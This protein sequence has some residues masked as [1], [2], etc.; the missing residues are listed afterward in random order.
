MLAL[1]AC[2]D[3]ATT[4]SPAAML[5][6][7]PADQVMF[8]VEHNM[9]TQGIRR[10]VLHGDT[11]FVH[12]GG[13]RIDVVGVR[14]VFFDENG[15][16]T[17]TLTSNTGTYQLRAGS[18]VAHGNAVLRTEGDDGTERTIE[19]EE[20]HFDV[21]GDRLWSEQPTVMREGGRILRGTSFESDG[22]FQNVTVRR[23]E[24]DGEPLNR[25]G[26]EITF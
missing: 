19:T 21:R 22:R 4:P 17:G 13:S 2:Q 16:Q 12:Q 9:T 24:T 15:R 10:A 1:A 18:M 26:G 25:P 23:A 8:G 14:M 20:L 7:M 3:G 11:A 6:E 5:Q